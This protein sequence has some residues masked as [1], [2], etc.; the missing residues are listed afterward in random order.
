MTKK[1]VPSPG[2]GCIGIH[3]LPG[4]GKTYVTAALWHMGVFIFDTDD[5]LHHP[6]FFKSY[7]DHQAWKFK[8]DVESDMIEEFKSVGTRSFIIGAEI[9]L[10]ITNLW[11]PAIQ[12]SFKKA[13]FYSVGFNP[14][15]TANNINSRGSEKNASILPL[16]K[17]WYKSWNKY[18]STAFTAS[19]EASRALHLSD[20]LGLDKSCFEG[21]D[22]YKADHERRLESFKRIDSAL[23]GK[24]VSLSV[25]TAVADEMVATLRGEI[26]GTAKRL[27]SEP[28]LRPFSNDLPVPEYFRKRM[29]LRSELLSRG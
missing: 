15:D 7:L 17:K 1:K 2:A 11:G 10:C 6:C 16:A 9:N 24:R 26:L 29:E 25:P 14:I 20:Y 13:G 19:M 4:S 5:L 18:R 8:D 21:F 22:V 27:S 23:D 12:P 3:A 28:T